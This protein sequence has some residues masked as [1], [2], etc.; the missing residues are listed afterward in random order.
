MLSNKAP[1]PEVSKSYAII[2]TWQGKRE[3][4]QTSEDIK[5]SLKQ[6]RPII[7]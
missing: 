4:N 1:A 2:K 6:F 7:K 3:Q 5:G